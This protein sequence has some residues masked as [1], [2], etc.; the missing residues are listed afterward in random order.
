MECL[1]I[2][3]TQFVQAAPIKLPSEVDESKE[4]QLLLRQMQS[5]AQHLNFSGIFVYQQGVHVRTSRITHL[6]DGKNEVE[7]LE[8]LDGP[9]REYVRNNDEITC[10]LPDA[11]ILLIENKMARDAFPN[12][13][14]GNPV[15]LAVF[16]LLKRGQMS[17]VAGHDTQ[18]LVLEPK[19]NLRYG[20]RLSA[21]KSTGLLLKAQTVNEKNEVIEQIT[22]TKIQIGNINPARLRPTFQNTSGWHVEN[23]GV[24][25]TD[26]AGWQVTSTP[27]GFKR[28]SA[29]KRTILNF[30]AGTTKAAGEPVATRDV[31][32]LVYSDGVAALSVFIEPA[33]RSRAD[34]FMQ[35]GAINIVAKR[36]GEFWL[37]IVGEVP[38]STVRQVANSIEFKIK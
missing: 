14:A 20:Y 30:A 28:I 34:E 16:Y 15:G 35:Q 38:A 29:I 17:H 1:L 25:Q 7:K 12:I 26:A 3:S 33:S 23:S 24:A 9:P 27:P 31:I 37:T 22:F 10:Y 32:Q 36:Q 11:R 19:D 13:V 8:I 18:E 4:V 5:A 2:L 21:E 6:L